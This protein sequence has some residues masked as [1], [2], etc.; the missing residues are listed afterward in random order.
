MIILTAA[1]VHGPACAQVG[2]AVPEISSAWTVQNRQADER[3][4]AHWKEVLRKQALARQLRVRLMGEEA[5]AAEALRAYSSAP[6][7]ATGHVYNGLCVRMATAMEERQYAC[8]QQLL[9]ESD[10]CDSIVKGTKKE[11]ETAEKAPEH[12]LQP[13]PDDADS[14][15]AVLLFLYADSAAPALRVL[16]KLSFSA[17]EALHPGCK[18]PAA[19]PHLAL[20]WPDHHSGRQSWTYL[21]SPTP[22]APRGSHGEV[23]LG[24]CTGTPGGRVGS[25][26]VD[27]LQSPRDG[28]WHP[29]GFQLYWHGRDPFTLPPREQLV[30][31]YTEQLPSG[32]EQ[33]QWAMPA[34]DRLHTAATRGNRAVAAGTALGELPGWLSRPQYLAL[35]GIRNAALMQLRNICCALHDRA[36]PFGE[37]C[38]QLLLRQAL[39]HVGLLRSGGASGAGGGG[40]GAELAWKAELSV[41]E[42]SS[43]METLQR[44]LLGFAEELAACI[45]NSE[46]LLAVI[47]LAVYLR[48]WDQQ[49]ADGRGRMDVL[50]ACVRTVNR[51]ALV[52]CVNFMETGCVTDSSS[53]TSCGLRFLLC[54]ALRCCR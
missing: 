20:D 7:G 2:S 29:C 15:L 24:S 12:V 36:L 33:L 23:K 18:A 35:C 22:G 14:A 38:V 13:L 45:S 21:Y 47:D 28:V 8:S 16:S 53:L 9:N 26:H 37:P 6:Y 41:R 49:P 27:H 46:A 44:E 40:G 43:L 32:A 19:G 11:L 17:Q 1:P 50:A 30:L 34:E 51:R 10:R 4:D 48:Y 25:A 39:Y 52:P 54:C 3:R 31:S 42:H 5:E